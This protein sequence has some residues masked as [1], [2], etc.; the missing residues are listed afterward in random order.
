M[1]REWS[2]DAV[3]RFTPQMRALLNQHGLQHNVCEVLCLA[4]TLGKLIAESQDRLDPSIALRIGLE[5]A[6]ATAN[7]GNLDRPH[8]A[9]HVYD[10]DDHVF[11]P[12]KAELPDHEALSLAQEAHAGPEAAPIAA[13][14]IDVEELYPGVLAEILLNETNDMPILSED[15][16]SPDN[17]DSTDDREMPMPRPSRLSGERSKFTAFGK[18]QTA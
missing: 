17:V 18:R 5:M 7:I 9:T 12:A 13:N 6:V 2:P 1:P 8:V 16:S 10:I 15:D 3:P 4:L 14:E 11:H